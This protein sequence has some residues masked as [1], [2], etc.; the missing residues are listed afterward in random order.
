MR[1]W[2]TALIFLAI[3]LTG[4]LLLLPHVINVVP[5]RYL[6]RLQHHPA[7]ARV[8]NW[9][10]PIPATLP[11]PPGSV[12]DLS[13]TARPA[14]WLPTSMP[15]PTPTPDPTGNAP[16]APALL[17]TA[18]PT[19]TPSPTPIPAAVT[20]S[21]MPVVWQDFSNC[22]P[23]N[24]SILLT[25]FGADISQQAIAQQIRPNE[26]DRNVTP[27]ELSAYVNSYTNLRAS[28]HSGG[29]L[30]LIRRLIAAGAPVII[31][32][33]YEV[34]DQGWFGHYLT[35]YGFDE[36]LGVF[37]SRDTS[38]GPFD[39][40]ARV[41]AAERIAS[42][43]RQFNNNFVVAY[44]AELA[45]AIT[46]ILGPEQLDPRQMWQHSASLAETDLDANPQDA[47]TWYNL[48]VSLV[49]LGDLVSGADY[50]ANAASA[51][52]QARR[53][54][55][56]PRLPFYQHEIFR[57]YQMSGRND[58]LL[59]LTTTLTSS[60]FGARYVEEIDWYHALAL[61]S[62]GD[63]GGAREFLERAL[64]VNPHFVPAQASLEALNGAP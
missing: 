10:R 34:Q 57:A 29:D 8:L 55:L 52:D 38:G 17:P 26:E 32:R 1:R 3:L 51:F 24:L 50:Y 48:G 41:D 59:W 2:I 7:T 46:A 19:V 30:D 9:V 45:S 33:G 6:V 56:P 64:R 15:S 12:A 61:S 47:F 42:M 16:R 49:H 23:A 43:W 37:Y 36:G 63:T 27:W 31:Q 18:S 40:T 28:A 14:A 25:Y 58:D 35:I 21:D 20:L 60:V 62:A 44:S 54:G 11:T 13:P 4:A 53:I 22:G 5:G 39:G